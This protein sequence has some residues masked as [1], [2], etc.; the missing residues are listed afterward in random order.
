MFKGTAELNLS[1]FVSFSSRRVFAFRTRGIVAVITQGQGLLVTV[2][3]RQALVPGPGPSHLGR[4]ALLY[5]SGPM[6]S[7]LGV[8]VPPS[9]LETLLRLCSLFCSVPA[10]PACT[11]LV[12]RGRVTSGMVPNP[13]PPSPAW[14]GVSPVPE[15]PAPLARGTHL[16]RGLCC[17]WPLSPKGEAGPHT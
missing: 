3:P 17:D 14:P 9:H 11:G 2:R 1:G 12:A 6:R 8:Y 4:S 7:S 5:A 13:A 16:P 15:L 10:L